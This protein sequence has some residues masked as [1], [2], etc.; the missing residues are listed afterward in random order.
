VQGDNTPTRSHGGVGLGLS[1]TRSL[2]QLLGGEI[3][4]FAKPGEGATFSVTLPLR[5][6]DDTPTF[7][8]PLRISEPSVT[9]PLRILVAEDNPVNQQVMQMMLDKLGHH[10][11][12][13]DNGLKALDQLQHARFDLVMLDVMMPTLDGLQVLAKW[14]AHERQHGGH[15]PI[16]MVTAH[17]MLGDEEKM[18]SAGADGY[19]SKPVGLNALTAVIH[20][21]VGAGSG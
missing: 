13:V 15:T 21:V 10:T 17:A 7:V 8:P 6:P 9:V 20:Q 16:V 2:V 14:R 11:V 5:L 1:I 4:A 19:V 12:L 3:H 18:L